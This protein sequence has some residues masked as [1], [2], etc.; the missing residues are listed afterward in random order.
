MWRRMREGSF[1]KCEYRFY[2]KVCGVHEQEGGN[3][4]H[5]QI[6]GTEL[7]F[8]FVRMELYRI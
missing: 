3:S 2:D 4:S 7:W 6:G 8:V 1:K 5:L